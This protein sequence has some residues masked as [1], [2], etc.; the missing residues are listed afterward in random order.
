MCKKDLVSLSQTPLDF[1]VSLPSPFASGSALGTLSFPVSE[2]IVG[3][4]LLICG[5]LLRMLSRERSS[6]PTERDRSS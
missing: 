1:S 2:M 5:I 6:Q 3:S 4:A